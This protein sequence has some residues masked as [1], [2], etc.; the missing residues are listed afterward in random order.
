MSNS[1]TSAFVG[2]PTNT[3]RDYYIVKGLLRGLGMED[4]D[5]SLGY[6]LA[7]QKPYDGYTYTPRMPGIIVG[8]SIVLVAII[9]ATG[10][11]LALRASMSS[12]R[13][14]A[15]D[16]ATIAAAVSHTHTPNLSVQVRVVYISVLCFDIDIISL[17]FCLVTDEY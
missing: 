4:A 12:M 1:S 11:R 9:A 8:L 15:D 13:F 6:P 16:W 10:T 14:G 7:A 2:Q 17:D 5:P 3:E